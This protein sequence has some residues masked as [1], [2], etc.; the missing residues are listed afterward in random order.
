MHAL[1]SGKY[2]SLLPRLGSK[3]NRVGRLCK[4]VKHGRCSVLLKKEQDL[5]IIIH[6][7]NENKVA[8]CPIFQYST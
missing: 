1:N 6:H 7:F 8:L 2:D 3:Y 4:Y 5:G